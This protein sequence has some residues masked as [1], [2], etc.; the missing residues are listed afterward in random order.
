MNVEAHIRTKISEASGNRRRMDKR[1]TP[2]S[3]YYEVYQQ[4]L[5]IKITIHILF[6]DES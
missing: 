1:R 3:F 6:M 5:F 2:T 4:Q